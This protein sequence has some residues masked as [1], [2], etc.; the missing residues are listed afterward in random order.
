MLLVRRQ[1][2]AAAT[3]RTRVQSCELPAHVGAVGGGQA[4]VVDE[5]A[6]KTRQDRREACRLRGL[7]DFPDGR[8]RGVA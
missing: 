2:R 6:G 7:Y 8:S 5:P 1:C 4:V 3:P